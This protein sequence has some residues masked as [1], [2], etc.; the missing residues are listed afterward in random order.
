MK[1]AIFTIKMIFYPWKLFFFNTLS[2]IT[3]QLE[4]EGEGYKFSFYKQLHFWS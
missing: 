3:I 4:G 2:S 1:L